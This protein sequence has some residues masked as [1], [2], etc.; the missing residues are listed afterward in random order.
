MQYML[1]INGTA[2][3]ALFDSYALAV[4]ALVKFVRSYV[5]KTDVSAAEHRVKSNG[6]LNVDGNRVYV[7]RGT[8]R[9]V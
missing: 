1:M 2:F 7:F 3:S 8:C 9:R 6:Y 5:T 4:E